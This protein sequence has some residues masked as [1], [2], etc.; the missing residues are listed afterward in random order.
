MAF[1][2]QEVSVVEITAGNHTLKH[3]AREDGGYD[4]F[5]NNYKLAEY[6]FGGG[7]FQ[8]VLAG[9]LPP[10]GSGGADVGT[11]VDEDGYVHVE[12]G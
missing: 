3:V 12:K 2:L 8:L 5:G 4:V 7:R 6:R 11:A 10:T 1:S 9:S